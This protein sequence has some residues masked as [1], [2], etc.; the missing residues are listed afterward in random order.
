M[1][2][3]SPASSRPSH[4]DLALLAGSR[5]RLGVGL[6]A[7][8]FYRRLEVGL[9]ICYRCCAQI[10]EDSGW[11]WDYFVMRTSLTNERDNI[12]SLAQISDDLDT[13]AYTDDTIHRLTQQFNLVNYEEEESDEGD[14]HHHHRTPVPSAEGRLYAAKTLDFENETHRRGFRFLVQVTDKVSPLKVP[15]ARIK[16]VIYL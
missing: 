1:C 5:P 11:G 7:A 2:G 9:T 15:S 6:T 12:T 4:C 10:L 16:R 14:F 3:V 13:F 8:N